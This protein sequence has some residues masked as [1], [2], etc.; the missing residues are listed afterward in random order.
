MKL[1]DNWPE[2]PSKARGYSCIMEESSYIHCQWYTFETSSG[3]SMV[4]TRAQ[5]SNFQQLSLIIL[6]RSNK[7]LPENS[8]SISLSPAVTKNLTLFVFLGRIRG[9]MIEPSQSVIAPKTKHIGYSM[10]SSSIEKYEHEAL[11][12]EIETHRSGRSSFRPSL[13]FSAEFIKLYR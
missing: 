13:T 5:S 9:L 6:S 8:Y 4:W 1:M 3:H 10:H 11:T 7:N 12:G 2:L